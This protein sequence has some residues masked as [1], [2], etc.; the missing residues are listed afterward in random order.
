MITI[1][2]IVLLYY[3]SKMQ[4]RN[5]ID[6]VVQAF[7]KISMLKFLSQKQINVFKKMNMAKTRHTICKLNPDSQL[8]NNFI[9]N[10]RMILCHVTRPHTHTLYSSHKNKVVAKLAVR[11]EFTYGRS[12]KFRGQTISQARAKWNSLIDKFCGH[13]PTA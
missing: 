11:I 7:Y 10:V 4:I 1:N 12:G 6:Q 9:F 3:H 13:F 8:G 2:Q 5:H